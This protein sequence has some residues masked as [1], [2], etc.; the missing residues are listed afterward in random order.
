[1]LEI[2]QSYKAIIEVIFSIEALIVFNFISEVLEDLKQNN[3]L[4]IN[5]LRYQLVKKY[6]INFK[7]L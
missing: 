5:L 2:R 4:E 6:L 3:L 1:V 7:V